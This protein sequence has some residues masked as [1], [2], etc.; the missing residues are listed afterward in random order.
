MEQPTLVYI[1]YTTVLSIICQWC[2]NAMGLWPLLLHN[3]DCH[4]GAHDV[5]LQSHDCA[6]IGLLVMMVITVFL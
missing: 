1:P 5:A 4:A 2:T 3:N 6:S